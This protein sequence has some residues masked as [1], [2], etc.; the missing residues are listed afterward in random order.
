[1]KP[2]LLVIEPDKEAQ[3]FYR[4]ALSPGD[5]TLRFESDGERGLDCAFHWRP[6][7]VLLETELKG[8]SGHDVCRQLKMD[9][10]TKRNPVFFIASAS[11]HKDVITGLKSGAD[12]YLPKPFHPTELLW[13][14][15]GLLR[16]FQSARVDVET[17]LRRGKITLDSEQGI[18]RLGDKTLRLTPK[19]FALLEAFLRRPNRVL[20]RG[21]LLETI[22]GF[23]SLDIKTRVVDLTLFRLR[24][25]L[26]K[27]GNRIETLPGFGYR[28]NAK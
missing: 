16:R 11:A 26:G 14:V 2:R 13:R 17:V 12:E 23:S 24:R 8:I 10:R 21:Y 22:W 19:E 18:C 5:F 1:M 7:C 15:K 25:K 20:K 9:D 27:F 28:L 3:R 6:D 4:E